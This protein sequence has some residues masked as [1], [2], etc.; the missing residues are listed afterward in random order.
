MLAEIPWESDQAQHTPRAKQK[1]V[2]AR[3]TEQEAR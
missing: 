3:S 1:G 2:A